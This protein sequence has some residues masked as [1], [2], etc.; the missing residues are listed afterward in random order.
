[1]RPEYP[2][3]SQHDLSRPETAHAFDPGSVA[4][5]RGSRSIETHEGCGRVGGGPCLSQSRCPDASAFERA[6]YLR[7]VAVDRVIEPAS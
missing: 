2:Q 1:M 7:A 6:Q 5:F 3:E 4:A